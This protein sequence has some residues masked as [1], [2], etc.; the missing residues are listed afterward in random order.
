MQLPS[1]ALQLF[2]I[3]RAALPAALP[4]IMPADCSNYD[5]I[6]TH[7]SRSYN[8]NK[9]LNPGFLSPAIVIYFLFLRRMAQPYDKS[10]ALG[11]K[12]LLSKKDL[13]RMVSSPEGEILD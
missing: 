10:G 8:P 2:H 11:K 4:L 6:T 1:F 7:F 5:M 13:E 3:D 12:T 9:L